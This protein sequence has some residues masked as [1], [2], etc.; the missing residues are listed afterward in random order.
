MGNF[1]IF[2]DNKIT[3]Y[4]G[5][6]GYEIKTRESISFCRKD[7][8]KEFFFELMPYMSEYNTK[9]SYGILFWQFQKI[10]RD[11][12]QEK[13]VKNETIKFD[14]FHGFYG[15]SEKKEY[16]RVELESEEDLIIAES[17]IKDIYENFAV[18]FFAE[19]NTLNKI[20]STMRKVDG[21]PFPM[22]NR[23]HSLSGERGIMLELFLTMLFLP[24]EMESRVEYY[25]KACHTA[26]K[27]H[28]KKTGEKDGYLY[29][30]DIMKDGIEK[31]K[32]A[33]WDKIRK[34]LI[35]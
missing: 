31:M 28:E 9:I 21:V 18:P 19:N 16:R 7:G 23:I 33:N 14:C 6:M 4:F 25:K 35:T 11:V 15:M 32:N 27:E 2:I 1:K 3:P 34:E 29:I 20:L 30:L 13:Y 12:M 26:S 5:K 10:Y 24:D 22:G 8:D 17:I